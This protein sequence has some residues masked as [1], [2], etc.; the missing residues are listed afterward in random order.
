ML[1]RPAPLAKVVNV[2]FS[3]RPLPESYLLLELEIQLHTLLGCNVFV[4]K[5]GVIGAFAF[6]GELI[7]LVD[8]FVFF[9]VFNTVS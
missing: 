9:S 4:G 2:Q 1:E 7:W 3:G 8:L 5:P 6:P